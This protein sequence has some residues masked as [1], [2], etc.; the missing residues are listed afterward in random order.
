[1][2]GPRRGATVSGA[3]ERPVVP[4]HARFCL[5][6]DGPVGRSRAGRPG[7]ERGTC[8]WCRVPFDLTPALR[9]GDVLAGD[10]GTYRVVEP[11]RPGSRGWVYRAEDGAGEPVVLTRLEGPEGV[12]AGELAVRE[13]EVLVALDVP[14]LVAARDVA[15]ARE[16]AGPSRH[17]VL[18]PVDGERL[19]GDRLDPAAA[20]DAVVGACAPLAALHARGLL[21]ADVTPANL[22]AGP[23]GV[24]LMDLGSVRRRDDRTSDVWATEGFVAPEVAPG[25]A[26]PSVA[27]DVYALGRT[28]AVL[29][30]DFDHTRS[31]ALRLPEPSRV[32][33]LAARPRLAALL[34]RATA[35]EPADRHRDVEAFGVEARAVRAEHGANG[36]DRAWAPAP[37]RD[38]DGR[39]GGGAAT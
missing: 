13:P 22:L 8:P 16:A 11:W 29:L 3:R 21:H 31:H 18:E 23:G 14:G 33:L 10:R 39:D 12:A 1:M 28:L 30:F 6:C 37:R 7:R 25:G 9:A 15:R 2:D 4:E 5:A 20:L 27:S 32:P 36:H 24:T 17:L 38:G 34:R 19:D 26:G 35:T